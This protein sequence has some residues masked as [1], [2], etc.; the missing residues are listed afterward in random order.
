[1]E[2]TF[3]WMDFIF[4]VADNIDEQKLKA[5]QNEKDTFGILDYIKSLM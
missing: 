1:M 2:K 3:E 5:L 4:S